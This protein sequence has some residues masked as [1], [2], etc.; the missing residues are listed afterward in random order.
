MIREPL[1]KAAVA[2]FLL[3]I[4]VVLVSIL[5]RVSEP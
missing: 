3:L 1:D 2:L 4:L 5:T